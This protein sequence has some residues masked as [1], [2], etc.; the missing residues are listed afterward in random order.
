M[1][2][3]LNHKSITSEAISFKF[4]GNKPGSFSGY[5]SKFNGNDAYNDTIVKGAYQKTLESRDRPVQLRWNHDGDIIGKWTNMYED[6]VGLFVEGEICVEHSKGA[7]V[8]ALMK[9][10]ALSGLSI[11]YRIKSSEK[12]QD[13]GLILKEIDLVEISVVETPA[14]LHATIDSVKSLI[15]EAEDLKSLERWLRDA[16]GISKTE[17]KSFIAKVKSLGIDHSDDAVTDEK[18]LAAQV[19]FTLKTL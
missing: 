9:Q 3:Q 4:D 18:S 2:Q 7:D 14:D 17:A 13:K 6:E 16:A 10:G 11:G 15:E 1:P 5:A 8:Y 12:K 19:L